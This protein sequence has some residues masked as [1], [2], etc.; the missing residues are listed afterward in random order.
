LAEINALFNQNVNYFNAFSSFLKLQESTDEAC[1]K[2]TLAYQSAMGDM[3]KNKKFRFYV[4]R[5]SAAY[6]AFEELIKDI[7]NL[8]YRFANVNQKFKIDLADIYA[9]VFKE[10][11]PVSVAT[12]QA[13]I[14]IDLSNS[15]LGNYTFGLLSAFKESLNIFD[16]NFSGGI[17]NPI[18]FQNSIRETCSLI[19]G[20]I[21]T[22][23]EADKAR[24]K[25]KCSKTIL[26]TTCVEPNETNLLQSNASAQLQ[27]I[28]PSAYN[29]QAVTIT[30]K[31][32]I[33]KQES[34]LLP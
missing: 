11:S 10:L 24:Q 33:I 7:Q 23:N 20:L 28:G 14:P 9:P 4:N 12:L 2:A 8:E 32:K 3:T 22:G 31:N 18:E 17:L 13:A 34:S 1:K 21:A 16:F 27:A 29:C 15:P 26:Y 30:R 19:S 25:Q 5:S 6:G